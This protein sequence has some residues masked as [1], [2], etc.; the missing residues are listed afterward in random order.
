MWLAKKKSRS[1]TA[2]LWWCRRS[3]L[4]LEE[5]TDNMKNFFSEIDRIRFILGWEPRDKW[6]EAV[7]GKL[8]EKARRKKE[9]GSALIGR[10]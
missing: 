3:I 4:R 10:V 8:C 6:A 9:F 2:L 7:V 5:N 1:G